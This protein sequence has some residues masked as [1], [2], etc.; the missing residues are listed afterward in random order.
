MN[1]KKNKVLKVLS[2]LI[3]IL[4]VLFLVVLATLSFATKLPFF[5]RLGLN[6]FNV[7]SGSMEPTLPVGSMVYAGKYKIEDL[8]KDDIITFK[9]RDDETGAVSVVTHRIAE[10][11]KDEETKKYDVDGE[12]KEKQVVK[13]EFVTK[14]DAN[15]TVDLW[16][17]PAGNVIGLYQWHVP[18]VGYV[19]NFSQTGK[20]FILLVII[21]AV[22]LIVWELASLITNIKNH[23]QEKAEKEI[24]KMKKELE[25]KS[26]KKKKK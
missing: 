19:T 23:Y 3:Q 17:V 21:P 1:I 9:V 14:G 15:N 18:F 20:G 25:K 16:T 22:I 5:S 24:A 12:E 10:V 11:I 7:T 8:K 26:S 4:L 6:F 2:A 13:Y